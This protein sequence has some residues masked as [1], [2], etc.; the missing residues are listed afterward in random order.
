MELKQKLEHATEAL[1]SLQNADGGIPATKRGEVSGCWTTADALDGVIS[2][3]SFTSSGI[4][5]IKR[6]VVFLLSMQIGA[7]DQGDVIEPVEVGAWPLLNSGHGS[8]MATGH[9]VAALTLAKSLVDDDYY[10]SG[11]VEQAIRQGFEWLARHQNNDGGW[12][13]QP[14][15][16]GDGK[17]S[18]IVATYY[19]LRA[20]WTRGQTSRTSGVV[21]RAV[22]FLEGVRNMDGSWGYALGHAGDI[23][24]TARAVTAL[25]KSGHYKATN[26]TI[27]QGIGFITEHQ[28]PYGLW[29]LAHEGFIYKDESG[30][31]IYNNSCVHDALVALLTTSTLTH[32]TQK[33][34][35]WF[36]STQQDDGLWTLSSPHQRVQQVY[37]WPTA[38][39]IYTIGLA[40]TAYS[41][42]GWES[43]ARVTYQ[44]RTVWKIAA[45]VGWTAATFEAL[46]A[47]GTFGLL[48]RWWA[49]LPSSGQD[50]ITVGI[51][52]AMVVNLAAAFLY[53]RMKAA[54]RSIRN[55]P[56]TIGGGS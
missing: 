5:R 9:A 50:I 20:Y 2:A 27:R 16:G 31:I 36:L 23:S 33:S 37:T 8:T 38:E 29:D 17:E 34:L 51:L 26:T 1:L 44:D 10:L 46:F 13:S 24:N 40:V 3:Q 11:R 14:G 43:A 32:T 21:L 41:E 47:L 30:Q 7:G 22:T 12:G 28:S 39:W 42:E 48:G 45:L 19:A 18:R 56:P 52:L 54:G 55:R 53:D 4:Q 15:S 25:V 49:S 6:M 35:A